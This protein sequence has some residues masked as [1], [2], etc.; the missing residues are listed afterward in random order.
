MIECPSCKGSGDGGPVHYNTGI[1]PHTGMCSGYW[2]HNS[3]C[4]RCKGTGIVPAEMAEWIIRGKKLRDERLARN[5]TIYDAA[6]KAGITSSEL[7]S[8]E[9]GYRPA[10]N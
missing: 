1:N 6:I 9:R 4:I 2:K 3:E 7:S 5:E 10:N 8:I